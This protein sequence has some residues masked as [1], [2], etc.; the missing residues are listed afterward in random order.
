MRQ[1][2]V[3]ILASK[4]YGVLYV[5]VT[6]SLPQ[7]IWQHKNHL[8]ESFTK[9]YKVTSL[10]YFELAETM[11]SAIGREKLLKKLG[12]SEKIDLINE[13]NLDWLDLY[14]SIL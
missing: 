11:E 14:P 2:A 6:S 3:Y 8:A 9:K 10:V 7:R 4:K 1:P 13:K 12:R 5:G